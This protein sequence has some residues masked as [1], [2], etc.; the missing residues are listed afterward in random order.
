MLK[1]NKKI[2]N[3]ATIN[4]DDNVNENDKWE[5]QM[6]FSSSS[7]FS[8][9]NLFYFLSQILQYFTDPF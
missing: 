6:T 9:K 8:L 1:K 2:K 3:K 5:W 4:E 7:S